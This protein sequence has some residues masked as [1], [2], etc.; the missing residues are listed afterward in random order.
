MSRKT[1]APQQC[2]SRRPRSAAL[3]EMLCP[4]E[5]ELQQP[6][7]AAHVTPSTVL[8]C[9][10]S[11]KSLKGNAPEAAH[12]GGAGCGRS[13][14]HAGAGPRYRLIALSTAGGCLGH[15]G[16]TTRVPSAPGLRS[17][18]AAREHAQR[19]SDVYYLSH[20]LPLHMN[21]QQRKPTRPPTT[22]T[23]ATEMPAMA[24]VLRLPPPVRT[25]ASPSS[26]C[27]SL[28]VSHMLSALHAVHPAMLHVTQ[29]YPLPVSA[30]P[31]SQAV[32]FADAMPAGDG[33]DGAV[34]VLQ[35]WIPTYA[36]VLVVLVPRGFPHPSTDCCLS[37][38]PGTLKY[39]LLALGVSQT[40]AVV[41]LEHM[42]LPG[43]LAVL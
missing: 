15:R 41:A 19:T 16:C 17:P 29:P 23:A 31:S 10:L 35:P 28:H 43:A 36:L 14:W 37:V 9:M 40:P 8:R 5:K 42:R 13:A 1:M 18:S 34:H 38:A 3:V 6:G 32:H 26:R 30:F 7:R 21:H 27:P 20:A 25:H 2:T 11:S 22:T 4:Y 33:A 39:L 12:R 24:P